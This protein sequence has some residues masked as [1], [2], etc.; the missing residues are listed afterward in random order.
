M[1][2]YSIVLFLH[3]VGAIGLFISLAVEWIGLR[4]LQNARTFDQAREGMDIPG[5]M[6]SVGMISML[7][8]LAAGF[9]MMATAWGLVAWIGVALVAIVLLIG[10]TMAL[11]SPRMAAI[12]K[13]LATEIAARPLPHPT[14]R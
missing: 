12:G 7:V 8:L 4:Q 9:Y 6:R 14:S 1:N 5:R 2:F 10:L 13:A 11:T 3:I